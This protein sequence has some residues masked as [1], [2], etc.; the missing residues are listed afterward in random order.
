MQFAKVLD[1]VAKFLDAGGFRYAVVG[2]F[3]LQSYGLSRATSDLDFVVE[4]KAQST[5]KAHLESLG[6]ET[7]HVSVGYSNHVHPLQG[8]SKRFL[9]IKRNTPSR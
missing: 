4:E 9:E 8:L 1:E 5:L 6:Y 3:G 2:A 7:T